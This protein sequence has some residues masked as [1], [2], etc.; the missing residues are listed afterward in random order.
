MYRYKNLSLATKT[1]YGVTFKP[2]DEKDVPGYINAPKFIRIS[3]IEVP[4]KPTSAASVV[5]KDD[6]KIDE[7]IN[8]TKIVTQGG[9]VDGSDNNK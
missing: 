6:K 8:D 9:K 4:K 3:K 7:V 5:K 2:G 1:F